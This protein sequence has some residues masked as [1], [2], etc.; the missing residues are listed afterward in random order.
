LGKEFGN[1]VVLKIPNLIF[2]V[3]NFFKNKLKIQKTKKKTKKQSKKTIKIWYKE[4][5]MH[6]LGEQAFKGKGA[7]LQQL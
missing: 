7:T 2:W 5:K 6:G 4:K 1:N 3:G